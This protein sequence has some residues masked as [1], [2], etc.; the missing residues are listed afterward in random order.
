MSDV[1]WR[2]SAAYLIRSRTG[3]PPPFFVFLT[4]QV[5]LIL[6]MM[7]AWLADLTT[8]LYVTYAVW[9]VF[10]FGFTFWTI[11]VHS[12]TRWPGLTAAQRAAKMFTFQR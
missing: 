12:R 2:D 5:F 9:F 6:I 10:F 4:G 1:T 7:G 3:M 8:M 11:L